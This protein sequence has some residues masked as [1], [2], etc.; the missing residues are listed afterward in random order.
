LLLVPALYY[1]LSQNLD[2]PG[3]LQTFRYLLFAAGVLV[4]G[5]MSFWG[6]YIPLVFPLHLRGTGESFAANIGGRV[7]GTAA[8]FI[9]L[10][11]SASEKPDPQKLA[12]VAA[13]VAAAYAFVGSLLTPFLPEPNLDQRG[14]E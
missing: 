13:G 9:T 8:A 10:T 11:L 5:Q 7:M 1:W 14:D 12:L 2:T 3:S 6:N 4:I